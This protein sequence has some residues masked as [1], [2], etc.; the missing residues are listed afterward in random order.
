MEHCSWLT[1]QMEGS[2]IYHHPDRKGA[3]G[4]VLAVSAMACEN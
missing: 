4:K 1:R 2:R 3:A